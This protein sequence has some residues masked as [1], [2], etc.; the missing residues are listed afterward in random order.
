MPW[1]NSE[2][3]NAQRASITILLTY[4]VRIGNRLPISHAIESIQNVC[5]TLLTFLGSNQRIWQKRCRR[6]TFLPA[7]AAAVPAGTLPGDAVAA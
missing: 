4:Y 2:A 3:H 5:Q 1:C 7:A 6:R